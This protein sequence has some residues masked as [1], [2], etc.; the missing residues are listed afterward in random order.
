MNIRKPPPPQ[1]SDKEPPK[2]VPAQQERGTNAVEHEPDPAAE[3]IP[4]G[5]RRHI[6]RSPYTTGND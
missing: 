5:E 2:P 1:G 4:D 3:R 6:R